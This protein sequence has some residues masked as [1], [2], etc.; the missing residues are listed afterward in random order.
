MTTYQ[1]ARSARSTNEFDKTDGKLKIST[2]PDE[3]NFGVVCEGFVFTLQLSVHNKGIKPIFV[4]AHCKSELGD[5]K[6]SIYFSNYFQ[7]FIFTYNLSISI[8]YL[9]L[10]HLY[11]SPSLSISL[12]IYL[13]GDKNE[14][15]PHY[16]PIRI[17]PGIYL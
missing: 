2:T 10:I 16:E 7:L 9:T 14:I 12:S 8:I 17:A 4:R 6:N 11:V 3:L 15:S 5:K 1:P 13:L